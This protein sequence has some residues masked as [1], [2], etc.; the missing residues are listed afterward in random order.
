MKKSQFSF[1]IENLEGG[2]VEM[3]IVSPSDNNSYTSGN[4]LD[5]N[6]NRNFYES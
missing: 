1:T 2:G 4:S 6:P 3:S 5:I